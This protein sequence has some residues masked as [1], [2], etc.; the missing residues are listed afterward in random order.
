MSL[1]IHN[2]DCPFVCHDI[3]LRYGDSL[4]HL[5]GGYVKFYSDIFAAGVYMDSLL[6]HEDT[7]EHSI[8]PF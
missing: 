7:D 3:A 6:L 2:S 1:S 5:F 8:N 4:W